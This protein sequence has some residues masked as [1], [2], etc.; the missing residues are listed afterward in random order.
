MKWVLYIGEDINESSL[1]PFYIVL[2]R[3]DDVPWNG[4]EDKHFFITS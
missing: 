3:Q 2:A 1:S 4:L